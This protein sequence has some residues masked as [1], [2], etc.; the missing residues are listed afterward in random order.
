LTTTTARSTLAVMPVRTLTLTETVAGLTYTGRVSVPAGA[1]VIDVLVETTAAW[2]AATAA[3]DVGDSD[4]N[5]A[6]IGA[7]SVSAQGA[8]VAS[9]NGGTDWG[10]GL[11]D[12]TGPYSAGGPGKLYPSGD[13]ITAVVTATVPGGPTGHTVVTVLYEF[14]G[15]HRVATAV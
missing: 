6:L 1:R 3:L 12:N 9:A 8:W 15:V 7:L 14:A 10:N 11:T 4:A 2:A 5:D 13:T